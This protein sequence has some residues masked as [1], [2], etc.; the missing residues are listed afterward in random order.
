MTTGYT[1]TI[2]I[3]SV[4]MTVRLWNCI[5]HDN[6]RRIR[7][8][9]CLRSTK[10]KK[11][12]LPTCHCWRFETN[13]DQRWNGPLRQNDTRDRPAGQLSRLISVDRQFAIVFS[14]LAAILIRT[15][16]V[17]SSLSRVKITIGNKRIDGLLIL[18]N[19]N[20]CW[21]AIYFESSICIHLYELLCINLK[22]R[23][24]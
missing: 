7:Q 19:Y 11:N 9:D 22:V 23:I 10:I 17:G 16:A 12:F 5:L 13:S 2:Q 6:I 20:Q 15:T 1:T 14:V 4:V 8:R 21:P 18:Y 3:W 24:V